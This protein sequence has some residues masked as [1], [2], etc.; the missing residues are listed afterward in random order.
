MKVLISGACGF[1]GSHVV[2]L[3]LKEGHTILCLDDLSS[4]L[5]SNLPEKID[6]AE[7]N[8][9]NWYDLVAEFHDFEPE[10]VI[11]LAAQP[12]ICDSFDNPIRDGYVNVMGSLNIIRACQKIGTQRL[13]FSSTSAVYSEC[14]SAIS[15][16]YPRL[17]QTPYGISK[18]AAESYIR[19]LMPDNSVVMRFGNVYGPRQVPLG[20]NQVVPRMIHHFEKGADFVIHGDGTQRRDMVYVDDVARACVASLTGTPG[21]YNIASGKSTSINGIASIIELIYDVPGYA[22]NHDEQEDSRRVVELNVT[23]AKEVLSWQPTVSL[24]EGLQKTVEWWKTQ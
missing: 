11:H 22:W 5:R 23:K 2:D 15:E 4:G 17:P 9:G 10:A 8:V 16:D 3:L 7:V 20:E 14:D 18:L 24:I 19:L 1:I 6:F 12:S 13:V 21:V